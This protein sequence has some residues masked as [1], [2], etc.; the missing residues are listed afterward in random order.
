MQNWGGGGGDKAYYGAFE[1]VEGGCT[2][3]SLSIF[4]EKT[5]LLFET[6]ITPSPHI[7]V[8]SSW[9][10]QRTVVNFFITE[11]QQLPKLLPSKFLHQSWKLL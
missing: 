3:S 4:L 5:L 10:S 7:A 2:F 9:S 8:A 1:N 6:I 11:R